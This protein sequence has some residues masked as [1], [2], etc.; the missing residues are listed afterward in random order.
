MMNAVYISEAVFSNNEEVNFQNNKKILFLIN[1]AGI[2]SF[3]LFYCFFF[4]ITNIFI[5]N[6]P[7]NILFYFKT[8][9]MM[10]IE[11]GFMLLALLVFITI[12]H[13]LVHGIF[14][15][16][17]T[18]DKPV[19]G[20]KKLAAYAGAPNWFIRKKY[21]Q[22][23]SLSPFILLTILN[24]V[25]LYF[26]SGPFTTILFIAASAHAAGCVGDI[27][28][29]LK[30]LNKSVDTYINDTGMVLRICN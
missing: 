5:A 24:F 23:I 25:V 6:K 15:Y 19:F 1:L 13:E 11:F 7:D 10:S 21:Y 14:F 30:L 20:Y 16:L 28:I 29:S 8:F 4:Y 2:I 12:V 3:V 26:V 9:R 27:W 18:G 22:V 17:Y